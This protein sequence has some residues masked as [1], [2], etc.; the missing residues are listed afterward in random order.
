MTLAT[1]AI[2]NQSRSNRSPIPF[3]ATEASS[4]SATAFTSATSRSFS[5]PPTAPRFYRHRILTIDLSAISCATIQA[6]LRPFSR[7]QRGKSIYNSYSYDLMI[8]NLDHR[9]LRIWVNLLCQSQVRC[10]EKSASHPVTKFLN[11]WKVLPQTHRP[12]FQPKLLTKLG[13]DPTSRPF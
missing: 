10:S 2:S 4:A 13:I 11:I 9:Y 5:F 3:R 12:L 1:G 7:S 8:R 6:N